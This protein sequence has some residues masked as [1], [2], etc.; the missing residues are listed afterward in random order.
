MSQ[1]SPEAPKPKLDR[2]TSRT[3]L[4]VH[5]SSTETP[6]ATRDE[7]PPSA[8]ELESSALIASL[9]RDSLPTRT[10]WWCSRTAGR[11][12]RAHDSLGFAGIRQDGRVAFHLMKTPDGVRGC[13]LALASEAPP[14]STDVVEEARTHRRPWSA[15]RLNT[16]A[17]SARLFGRS[18]GARSS[19]TPSGCPWIAR[20]RPGSAG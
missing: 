17:L 9:Q 16:R 4:S 2:T 8:R 18:R 6:S 19:P 20:G 11:G 13:S 10:R 5:S 14:A 3:P 1:K 7:R 15:G 12:R